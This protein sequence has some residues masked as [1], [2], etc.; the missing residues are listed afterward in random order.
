MDNVVAERIAK[1]L[2]RIADAE[3]LRAKQCGE[4]MA[5]WERQERNQKELLDAL[6]ATPTVHGPEKE[7]DLLVRAN[8]VLEEDERIGEAADAYAREYGRGMDNDASYYLSDL[9]HAA[10]CGYLKGRADR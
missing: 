10:R 2:E 9:K 5:V 7:N 4:S 3:E 1:A 6:A 8:L